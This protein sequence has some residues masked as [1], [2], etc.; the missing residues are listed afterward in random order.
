MDDANWRAQVLLRKAR[1]DFSA[2]HCLANSSEVSLWTVGFHAQQAVEKATKAV[3]IKQ[4]IRYPFTHDIA[5]LF[6][7]VEQAGL[8]L[9]HSSEDMPYLTPFGTLFRYEDE[10]WGLPEGLNEARILHWA[11]EA[12]AW[13]GSSVG[14]PESNKQ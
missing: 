12:V 14:P 9:P 7:L 10:E 3:L 6:K 1:D 4:G 13:A 8:P 2:A 5:A 11:E